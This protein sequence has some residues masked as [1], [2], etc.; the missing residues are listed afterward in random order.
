MGFAL[1]KQHWKLENRRWPL[2][3]SAPAPRAL[4]SALAPLCIAT[5]YVQICQLPLDLTDGLGFAKPKLLS[6]VKTE[7]FPHT[8]TFQLLCWPSLR[9][10]YYECYSKGRTK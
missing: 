3:L 5:L 7:H 1:E 4:P 10:T 6:F 8:L 9:L 2:C